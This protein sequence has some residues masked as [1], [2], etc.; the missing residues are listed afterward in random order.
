MGKRKGGGLAM[1]A[2]YNALCH[3]YPGMVDA[4]MPEEYC[5]N[6]YSHLIKAPKRN[7]WQ[8]ITGGSMHR[9]KNFIKNYLNNNKEKYHICVINGGIYAGD[10]MDMIHGF[11]LKIM[12]I[13]HNF[14]REYHLDNK[15][16]WT[17]KGHYAGF[18]VHNE[19]RAYKKADVNCFLTN[20][21]IKLFENEYGKRD[22]NCLVGVFEPDNNPLPVVKM[23][24]E[25]NIIGITGSMNSLQTQEGIMDLKYNYYFWI[26]KNLRD[27]NLIIAGRDPSEKIRDFAS[28][29][30][31]RIQ[32]IPNPD[33]MSQVIDKCRIFLCPTNVGGGLKLRV[34][35]GLRQ[36]LP[37]IA[38]KISARGYDPFL[39]TDFFAVYDNL[40]S[41][42]EGLTKLT[43][44]DY[45]IQL[46]KHIQEEYTKLFG[47]EQG[48]RRMRKCVQ[49]L[50]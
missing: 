24:E 48:T 37:V 46:K 14:E 39:K 11:G 40:D 30:N 45:N 17:L 2:Y 1:K 19:K 20:D 31:D 35:D 9:Y 36:G 3:L 34:M 41:F 8:M 16:L 44:M 27:W 33:D 4:V 47:F 49:I 43:K 38:H 15:D 10:M 29:N 7:L 21:D 5:V 6:Q 28:A 12:V 25:E 50:D 23:N 22:N 32:L 42:K 26:E 13:H 18:V